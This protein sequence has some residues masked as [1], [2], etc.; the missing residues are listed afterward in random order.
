MRL[1]LLVVLALAVIV[2]VAAADILSNRLKNHPSP[3]LAMHGDDPVA[4]QDWGPAAIARARREGK[5]LFVS[6]G[7]FTCHWCHV[8]QRESYKNPVI[9][10]YINRHFVPVKVDRELESALDARLIE[11]AERTQGQGGWPLNV[12]LTPDGY[13][14][15]A[16]LYQP[17]DVFREQIQRVQTLWASE[18]QSLARLARRE[19]APAHGPGAPRLDAPL[20][21]AHRD[22]FIKALLANAD[23]LQGG[24]GNRAKFPPSPQLMLV[25]DLYAGKPDPK[26]KEF[27][28]LTLDAMAQRGLYDHVGGGFF[29]YTTDPSWKTPHFEK[30]LYDNA[31]LARIYHRAGRVLQ[32]SDYRQVAERTIRFLAREMHAREGAFLAALSAVDDRNVEGGY[33]L[34]PEPELKRLLTGEELAVLGH[35][36]RM[37]GPAP[38]EAG[39]LPWRAHSPAETAKELRL[40]VALVSRYQDTAMAKLFDARQR[41]SLPRDTKLLAGWNG[42]ML[43]TLAEMAR[44]TQDDPEW[45]RLARGTRDY[46]VKHLW[47]DDRLRRAVAG[48]RELGAASLE[49]YAYVADG[50]LAWARLTG[51]AED[52]RL[53]LEVTRAAWKRF[54]S[55]QG[56]RLADQSLMAAEPGQDVLSDG[57]MP[58]PSGVLIRVSL[59]L[60]AHR[61][62]AALRQQALA[63]LNSGHRL[64]AQD[65]VWHASHIAAMIEAAG[66]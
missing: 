51:A 12:F 35:A 23:L 11:F 50:L 37:T 8:M 10:A 29:R 58:A 34:W 42:L 18:G 56:W 9:A 6:V 20:V 59:A 4:W 43:T 7:Y 39:H 36:F 2:Q 61:R 13:P 64:I 26:L 14:L 63:A 45:Q 31:Q 3:Y 1:R 16:V 38:F 54:Y 22:A 60:A 44:E 41:R 27:L 33:Y 19:A 49:D 17:P 53:A 48:D 25:L 24:L 65:P 32:R 52:Y 28:V 15:F 30:M 40:D 47:R 5:L 57:P 46:L 62:D 55:R 21:A 66:R